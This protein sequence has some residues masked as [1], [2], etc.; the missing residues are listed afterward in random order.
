VKATA[1]GT[2]ISLP[3]E[4]GEMVRSDIGSYSEG[5][6]IAVVADLQ[7]MIVSTSINEADIAKLHLGQEA[8]IRGMPCPTWN[9]RAR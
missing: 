8:G 5:T 6:V 7:D 9:T 3:V 1:A 4:E 2:I